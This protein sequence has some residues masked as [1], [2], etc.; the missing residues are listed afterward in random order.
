MKIIIL[1]LLFV[2]LNRIGFSQPENSSARFNEQIAKANELNRI[3]LFPE[4][5]HELESAIYRAKKNKNDA[6]LI[7]ATIVLAELMR[8]TQNYEK[9]L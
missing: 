3:N 6:E 2:S 8:R 5:I 4:S 9:G 7:E 1:F